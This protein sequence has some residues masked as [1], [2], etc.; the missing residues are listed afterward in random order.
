MSVQIFLLGKLSGLEEFLL[1]P[2]PE[3][4]SA[5]ALAGRSQWA[6]L[7]SEVIPRG[8]LAELG[9]SPLL[10]GT[11]GGG[12]FLIVLPEESRV[13]AEEI[14]AAAKADIYARSGARLH[15]V[16]AWTE[17]LGDWSIVRKRLYTSLGRALG[18]PLAVPLPGP[19]AE[20]DFAG[21]SEAF[22]EAATASWSPDQPGVVTVVGGRHNWRL[23]A[24][25]DDIHLARHTALDDAGSQP[26]TPAE[27]AARAEGSQRWGV[28]RGDVDNFGVRLRT[29]ADIEEHLRLS[30]VMKQ[31]F[32]GEIELACNALPE[33]W[34]KVT[35]LYTGGDDFAVYG[36]WDA[37]LRLATEFHRLFHLFAGENLKFLDGPE[38]KTISMALALAPGQDTPFP[39]V[40]EEA[41]RLLESAKSEEKDCFHLFGRTV[42]WKQVY[43]ASGLRDDLLRLIRDFRCPPAFLTEF[44]GFY[45]E[46]LHAAASTGTRAPGGRP[47]RYHRRIGLALGSRPG[48]EFEKLRNSVTQELIGGSAQNVRLRPAGRV[49]V[50]WTRLSIEAETHV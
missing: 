34:R 46:K 18:T 7:L 24:G 4:H 17:N 38:A 50:E 21:F 25:P 41:G 5:G 10:L 11:S 3:A 40:Y 36:S 23:G 39:Y 22:R 42:D 45:R 37:L 2:A 8:I 33:L 6:A 27:L 14:L 9:L 20:Q 30:R 13:Q 29:C 35:I 48:R 44:T 49:A 28:L 43:R 16:W 1:S 15:L 12:Q 32:A 31:F 47:W 19:G 26:A